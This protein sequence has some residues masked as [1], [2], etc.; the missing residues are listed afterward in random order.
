VEKRK[1]PRDTFDT[2]LAIFHFTNNKNEKEYDLK[3]SVKVTDMD[4]IKKVFIDI[5]LY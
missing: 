1:Y 3:Y 4:K 5:I 2:A